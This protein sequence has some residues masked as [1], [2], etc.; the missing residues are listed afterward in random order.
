MKLHEYSNEETL[1]GDKRASPICFPALTKAGSLQGA[2]QNGDMKGILGYYLSVSAACNVEHT[3]LYR[4]VHSELCQVY[5]SMLPLEIPYSVCAFM[6]SGCV[7][8]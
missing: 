5:Y 7:G 3:L 2:I 4:R 1:T 6:K 8:E